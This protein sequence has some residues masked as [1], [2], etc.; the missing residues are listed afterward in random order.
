MSFV[1]FLD[2][3]AKKNVRLRIYT[4]HEIRFIFLKKSEHLSIAFSIKLSKEIFGKNKTVLS[5]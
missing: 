3:V 1:I 2:F 4:H 5:Q